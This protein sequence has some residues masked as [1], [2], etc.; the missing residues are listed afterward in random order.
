M[1]EDLDYKQYNPPGG[2]VGMQ[3]EG[4]NQGHHEPPKVVVQ[5]D[6]KWSGKPSR[7][8][9]LE[10]DFWRHYRDVED[11]PRIVKAL[12]GGQTGEEQFSKESVMHLSPG[13]RHNDNYLRSFAEAFGWPG[14]TL[15]LAIYWR[16]DVHGFGG[17][18]ISMALAEGDAPLWDHGVNAQGQAPTPP[19]G[20]PTPQGASTS[21][22]ASTLH[23]PQAPPTSV[24]PPQGNSGDQF[25]QV[26]EMLVTLMAA[27]APKEETVWDRIKNLSF[28]MEDLQNIKEKGSHVRQILEGSMDWIFPVVARKW[29]RAWEGEKLRHNKLKTK[30]VQRKRGK[31]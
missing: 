12:V 29:M 27:Q 30:R 20:A 24:T 4:F 15:R 31:S 3:G 23:I 7:G 6:T 9:L 26:M 8:L 22:G 25:A 11:Q 10:P 2:A 17:E 13:V 21:Q 16:D 5:A 18:L 28:T 1:D 19:Q 14:K